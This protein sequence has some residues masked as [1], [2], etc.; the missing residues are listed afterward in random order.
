M[1]K[2]LSFELR[3]EKCEGEAGNKGAAT[4]MKERVLDGNVEGI[5]EH[6][7]GGLGLPKGI[8]AYGSVGLEQFRGPGP[9]RGQRARMRDRKDLGTSSREPE[10]ASVT[11]STVSRWVG[12]V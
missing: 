2:T 7:V 11:D 5:S 1:T 4:N 8:L 9:Q 12:E 6:F 3:N 10:A